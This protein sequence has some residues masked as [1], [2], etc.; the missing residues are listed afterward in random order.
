MLPGF[1]HFDLRRGCTADMLVSSM[2]ALLGDTDGINGTFK[3]LGL[4]EISALVV[5]DSISGLKGQ[6]VQFYVNGQLLKRGNGPRKITPLMNEKLRPRWHFDEAPENYDRKEISYSGNPFL[7][8]CLNGVHISLKKL[9]EPFLN[10]KIKPEVSALAIKILENLN[11]DQFIEQKL[12]GEDALWLF[13]HLAGLVSEINSLDPKFISATRIHI[14]SQ[15]PTPKLPP[16]L[17]LSHPVW[18]RQVMYQLPTNEMN[19]IVYADVL[20]LA[21]IKT[22]A[23]HFGPRGESTILQVGIG[24]SPTIDH[25]AYHFIEAL[26]CEASLPSSINE[27]GPSNRPRFASLFEATGTV[28]ATTDMAALITMMSLHGAKS[29]SYVLVQSEKNSSAYLVRFVV[30]DEYKREAIEA[31]LIKGNAKDLSLSTVEHQELN[32][33]IVNV[34]LGSGNKTSSARFYE[35]IYLDKTVRVEPLKEDL[36]NYVKSTDYS[37]DVARGDLLMAWKKWRAQRVNE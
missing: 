20:A 11:C 35:Y 24:L 32:K 34:P 25:L 1:L 7:Q 13:C 15:A 37:I 9:S 5:K 26:W 27:I 14:F 12:S 18:L 28:L 16:T 6:V 23:G 33:R 17:D 10:P 31:F 29:L 3:A 8:D 30:N 19:E 22:L 21:F 2:A 36:D 4:P